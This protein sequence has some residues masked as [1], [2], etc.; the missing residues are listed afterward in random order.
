MKARLN[1]TARSTERGITLLEV[2]VSVLIFSI[3]ILGLVAM[4]ARAT[5][6]S[7]DAEDR[8]RAAL[9]A[10]DIAAQMHGI[11]SVSLSASQISSWQARVAASGVNGG[12]PNGVGA[13]SASGNAATVTITWRPTKAASDA[14]TSQ[15]S[16]QVL[17][18][19]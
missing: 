14:D 4:Q 17:V 6:Y 18:L 3:G 11:R 16:T 7:L 13:I 10:D 9:L 19:P 8:N 15:Y 12:V 5:Q 2:L 1:R